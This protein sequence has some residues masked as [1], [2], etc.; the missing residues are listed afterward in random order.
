MRDYKVLRMAEA[1]GLAVV[2]TGGGCEALQKDAP[3][4]GY[5][6]ITDAGGA[7]VPTDPDGMVLLGR[8]D[9]EGEEVVCREFP[10]LADAVAAIGDNFGH[11]EA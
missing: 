7:A 6:W 3:D 11:W 9:N 10:S 4:G 8:Y 2:G 5:W 1:A